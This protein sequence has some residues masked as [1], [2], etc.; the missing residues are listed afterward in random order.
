M[1]HKGLHHNLL[2]NFKKSK[3]LLT[4]KVKAN[5]KVNLHLEVLNRRDDNYHNI[6]SLNANIDL[7][8][9]LK[10]E[11]HSVSINS[12]KKNK[13]DIIPGGGKY[14]E[15]LRSTPL[16][17]NLITKSA[18]LFLDRIGKSADIK[19]SVKKNI[20]SGAGL[21]GGSSD[22]AATIRFLNKYFK[23]CL[24]ETGLLEIAKLTGSD[25]PYCLYGGL[26]VCEG[27][28]ERIKKLHGRLR[29]RVLILNTGIHVNTAAAY[30]ALNR[31]RNYPVDSNDIINKQQLFKEGIAKG[32]IND[33]RHILKNDFEGPVFRQYPVLEEI[34][35]KISALG[36]VYVTMTGSGSTIIALFN[37][38]TEA[39]KATKLLSGKINEIYL[40]K[41]T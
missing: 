37:K 12:G 27:T 7:F 40:A 18:N 21:G 10:F 2:K 41:F 1:T 16:K 13:I 15:I 30:N 3:F 4:Y 32:S 23:N 33:F 29:Y 22:A 36:P 19:I 8:D 25:V 11:V 24:N 31:D 34:K 6:F 14:D 39:I 20:P 9:L 17:E 5:A 26:S 35:N 38:N 28:G